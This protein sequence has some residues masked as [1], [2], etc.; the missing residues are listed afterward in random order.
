M[1]VDIEKTRKWTVENSFDKSRGSNSS[2]QYPHE[3]LIRIFSSKLYSNLL[4]D[5]IPLKENEKVLEIGC[6]GANNLRFFKEKGC[7]VF[8][9]EVTEDL[10][11]LSK[12][13]CLELGI[14]DA[15][16]LK[17]NNHSLPF[18]DEYFDILVSIN[19][20]HYDHGLKNIDTALSNFHRVLR[21]GGVAFIETAAPE[22]FIFQE[23]TKKDRLCFES[24]YDDFRKGDL[25]GFFETK[26]QF[27]K[28]LLKHFSSV[29]ILTLTESYETINLQF[30]I[31]IVK[32]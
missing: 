6:M 8:G 22:H 23:A 19:T 26:D 11:A 15:T 3:I 24:N 2:P 16:I 1:V 31:G 29:E 9:I 21:K 14:E 4:N 10:V 30:F 25:F 17:G 18:K 12:Q 5:I 32:K 7:S 28:T 13:R 27:R 20:L